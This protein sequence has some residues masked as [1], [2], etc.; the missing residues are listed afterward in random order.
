MPR[1]RDPVVSYAVLKQLL[2]IVGVD[3]KRDQPTVEI[4]RE[5]TEAVRIA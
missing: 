3:L 1:N 4:G 5:D 2:C